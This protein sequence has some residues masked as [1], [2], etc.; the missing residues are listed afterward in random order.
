MQV[1][2]LLQQTTHLTARLINYCAKITKNAEIRLEQIYYL[3]AQQRVVK[4]AIHIGI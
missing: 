2:P 3:K 1:Q 4:K